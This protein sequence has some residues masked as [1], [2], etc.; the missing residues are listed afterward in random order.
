MG[1][2]IDGKETA[3]LAQ[4]KNEQKGYE[5]CNLSCGNLYW[6]RGTSVRKKRH[7]KS[8]EVVVQ[9]VLFE[10]MSQV[11]STTV[12]PR[13]T[14]IAGCPGGAFINLLGHVFQKMKPHFKQTVF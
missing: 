13:P 5:P 14:C 11:A 1:R 6:L 2:S 12:P 8:G 10:R 3:W 7:V 4:E 9:Q